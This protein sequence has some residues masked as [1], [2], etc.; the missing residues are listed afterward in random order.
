MFYYVEHILCNF[1]HLS[2]ESYDSGF[3]KLASKFK[4]QFAISYNHDSNIQLKQNKDM[5]QVPSHS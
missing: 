2:S 4:T 3:K 5:N 1:H